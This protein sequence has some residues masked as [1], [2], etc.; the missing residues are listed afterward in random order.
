[1]RTE[2]YRLYAAKNTEKNASYAFEVDY[3]RITEHYILVYKRGKSPE[4]YKEIRESDTGLLSESDLAWLRETNIAIMQDY[5]VRHDTEC[6]RAQEKFLSRFRK[7]LEAER[8]K[9]EGV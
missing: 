3:F 1:M 5:M 8:K 4:G 2:R 9:I 7:E 6:R